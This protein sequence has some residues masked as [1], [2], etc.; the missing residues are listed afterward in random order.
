MAVLKFHVNE[1]AL[2]STDKKIIADFINANM[3]QFL[4]Y[5]GQQGCSDEQMNRLIYFTENNAAPFKNNVV[6]VD[7]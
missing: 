6:D 3:G 1:R 7:F 4:Y 2:T 5:C